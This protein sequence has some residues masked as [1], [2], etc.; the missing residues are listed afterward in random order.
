MLMA[1][2]RGEIPIFKWENIKDKWIKI[3][4]EQLTDGNEFKPDDNPQNGKNK[5]YPDSEYLFPNKSTKTGV[6]TNRA[7]YEV[8]RKLCKKL[9]IIKKKG[10]IKG[11]HSFRRNSITFLVN[12]NGGDFNMASTIYGNS[13]KV[14]KENYYAGIDIDKVCEILNKRTFES[15]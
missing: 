6:I 2:R 9:G 12:N 10:E 14:A 7:V 15:V 11:P 8:Y 13:P 5:I 4:T 1:G 3:T